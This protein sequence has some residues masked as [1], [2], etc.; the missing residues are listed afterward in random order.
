MRSYTDKRLDQ[1]WLIFCMYEMR[2]NPSIQEKRDGKVYS[3]H[4]WWGEEKNQAP[5][6]HSTSGKFLIAFDDTE[7]NCNKTLPFVL[8]WSIWLPNFVS[9]LVKHSKFQFIIHETTICN[10]Y[11]LCLYIDAHNIISNTISTIIMLCSIWISN[12]H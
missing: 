4:I 2:Q 8:F 10:K 1:L 3:C 6:W 7:S 12:L 9:V 11:T 5:F